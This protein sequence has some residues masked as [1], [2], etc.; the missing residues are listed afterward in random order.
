M[1]IIDGMQVLILLI[2]RLPLKYL[3]GLGAFLGLLMYWFSKKDKRLI[4]ENL[5][6]AQQKYNFQ[7]DPVAVAKS[8]GQMLTDSLWI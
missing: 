3:Q 1:N 8:A 7:A 5:V 2:S 6:Q 4:H